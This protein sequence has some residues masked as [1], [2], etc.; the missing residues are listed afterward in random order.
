MKPTLTPENI[1]PVALDIVARLQKNNFK[2]YLVGGCVR[3]LLVGIIPKDFDIVTMARP[4][5]VQKIIRPSF[6]IGRRFRLVLVRRYNEQ[7]EIATFRAASYANEENPEAVDENIYGEP[8]EDALRRDFTINGLFYDP[9]KNEV[10][11]YTHGLEDIEKR[12]IRMIGDPV[13]RIEQDPI[14]ILRALRLAHRTGF[15]IE[16]T[17][18]QAMQ[19][20]AELLKAA[21]LPR[22]REEIIKIL[23][24][25][26][27]QLALLEG[28]DLG[29]IPAIAPRLSQTLLDPAISNDFINILGVGLEAVGRDCEPSDLYSIL[30]YSYLCA[31]SADWC[32]TLS[33]KF[34]DAFM[35][36]IRTELGMHRNEFELFEQT[37][38]LVRQLIKHGDPLKLRARHRDHLVNNR[39]FPLALL[40]ATTYHHLHPILLTHWSKVLAKH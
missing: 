20:R 15:Q 33:T 10:I 38:N 12:T 23:R 13:E 3:D 35:E 39:A 18:R 36:F 8:K 30:L 7:Y 11:D 34:D 4:E 26:A 37:I 24:L 16:P 19:E 32:T 1:D 21:V 25:P 17:L 28:S 40:I 6:I 27:P 14:R 22:V 9:S 29:I 31:N 5:Q 2:T